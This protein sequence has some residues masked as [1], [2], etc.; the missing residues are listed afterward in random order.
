MPYLGEELSGRP[1]KEAKTYIPKSFPDFPSIHTYK[2]TPQFIESITVPGDSLNAL[3]AAPDHPM[4]PSF[5]AS[6]PQTATNG[7]TTP[8][9]PKPRQQPL[10]PHEIPRGDPKKLREA[11]T[12][13]AKLGEEALRRLMRASKI[14]KQ[15]E[16]WAVAQ[17][18]PERK[19]RMELW[20]RAM[21]E[22]LN[23][24]RGVT[25]SRGPGNGTDASVEI[26]DHSMVVNAEMRFQRQEG[27][28][29]K[30]GLGNV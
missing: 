10:L 3:N 19:S 27:V 7:T 24:D 28:R 18:D 15:K 4:A 8:L 13:E 21:R 5:T 20:D 11:A 9:A 29:G 25:P 17:R 12:K 23:E 2:N 30:T 6:T 22:L 16:V 14:A 26:A 1:E